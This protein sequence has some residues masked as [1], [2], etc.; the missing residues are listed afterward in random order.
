MT[1]KLPKAAQTSM[2]SLNVSSAGR[3]E[4]SRKQRQELY[5]GRTSNSSAPCPSCVR[6]EDYTKPFMSFLT[7]NPT[8]FHTVDYFAKSVESHGFSKLSEREVW[9]NKLEKGRKYYVERN[10]SSMVAFVIGKEYQ[11]GNGAAIVAG[12]IDALTAR[13][14]P[15]TKLPNQAGYVQLGVAPYAGGFNSTWWDRDLGIGG[16]VL[17]KDKSSGKIRT[18]LVK[19]DWP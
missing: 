13:L 19:L 9:N 2:A 11:P 10:G 18:K 14:K 8:V 3:Q 17:V 15:I 4:Q 16:R 5:E 7:E 6:P 12:H 1:K